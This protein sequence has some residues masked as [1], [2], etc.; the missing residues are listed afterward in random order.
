MNENSSAEK[1]AKRFKKGA[2]VK[3]NRQ[4]Y[5]K[6]LESKASDEFSHE[7]IFEGPGEI[8][9]IKE[10]YC[11]IRWRKPVPDVWL[12]IDQLETWH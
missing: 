3:V 2:L 4:A 9:A 1:P 7:Y 11:Q 10:E 8:L 6:S 12:K 5:K